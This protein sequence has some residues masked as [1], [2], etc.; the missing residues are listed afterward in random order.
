MSHMES[1]ITSFVNSTI[2]TRIILLEHIHR[3]KN[4]TL[5]IME[6]MEQQ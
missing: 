2:I 6:I 5:C 3:I 4:I 1:L